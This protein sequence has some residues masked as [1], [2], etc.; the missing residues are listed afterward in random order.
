M[1]T[2]DLVGRASALRKIRLSAH[3]RHA[4]YGHTCVRAVCAAHCPRRNAGFARGLGLLPAQRWDFSFG[5]GVPV[6]QRHLRP[7]A[8]PASGATPGFLPGHG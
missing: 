5:R 2:Q 8:G 1:S 3:P 7:W 4:A 6:A